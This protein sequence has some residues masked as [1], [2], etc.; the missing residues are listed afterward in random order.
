MKLEML[1][2]GKIRF[3]VLEALANANDTITAYQIAITKGLDPAATY[4][5]LTEFSE[6]KIVE[7]ETKER[8]QT[9]YKLSDGSGQAAAAFLRSLKQKTPKIV[10]LEEWLSPKMQAERMTKFVRLDQ[11]DISKFRNPQEKQNLDELMSKRTP[12]ELSALITTS[13]IAFNELF[14]KEDNSFILRVR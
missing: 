12:G 11:S 7:S 14:E 4:R 13:K 3:A 9:F 1:F 10:N 8:N 5:C 6:F 2:G